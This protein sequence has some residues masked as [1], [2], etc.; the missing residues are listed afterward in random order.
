MPPRLRVARAS[1]RSEAPRILCLSGPNLQ[2]LGTREPGIYGKETLPRLYERLSARARELGVTIDC[3]QTNHE[4]TLCDWI[5]EAR[6]G[7]L[8]RD[9]AQ[10]GRVHAHVARALRRDQSRRSPVRR[11]PHLEPRGARGLP[12]RV[13]HPGSRLRGAGGR[14][15]RG[16]LSPSARRDR[17]SPRAWVMTERA[18]RENATHRVTNGK[19][20]KPSKRIRAKYPTRL[21]RAKTKAR[22]GRDSLANRRHSI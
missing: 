14:L 11:G 20:E 15:R 7:K 6:K 16:Q 21:E 1:R 10:C 17:R 4:G 5:A 18:V 2:L 3:R 9:L 19:R 22:S 8:R 13:A 12:S